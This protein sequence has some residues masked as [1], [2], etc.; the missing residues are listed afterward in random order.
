MKDP[1]EDAERDHGDPADPLHDLPPDW[2]EPKPKARRMNSE[3]EEE[4]DDEC[5]DGGDFDPPAVDDPGAFN[6]D[7]GAGTQG[8]ERADPPRKDRFALHALDDIVIGDDPIEL[9]RGILPMGPALGVVYGPPKSLK[10]FFVTHAGLHIAGNL[11]YCGREVQSGAVVYVTS[12]GVKG[13]RRRLVT[14]RR[15][16]GLEGKGVPFFLVPAMPNLG[17]GPR[18]REAL[19][20]AIEA[21]MRDL[22][23]PLR[24]IVID[25]MRRAMPGKSENKPEDISV[26]VDN[27]EALSRAFDCLVVLVHHSPRSDDDRGSGSNATDAAADVMIGC[28]RDEATKIATVTVHRLKDGEEGDAWSFELRPMEIGADRSGRPIVSRYVQITEEPERNL[29]TTKTGRAKLSAEQQRIYDIL[30]EAVA[31]EGV[32]GLAGS[33]APANTRAIT[34]TTLV[35]YLKRGGWWDK[36]KDHSSRS[37]MSARL[38][39]LAGKHAIG[40]TE[41]HVWPAL[42]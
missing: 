29:T 10:S 17:A 41:Q 12:E 14:A 5:F 19:Q 9:V 8:S 20:K 15:A 31:A 7:A 37:K 18:D 39:E 35:E 4:F 3:H 33:A 38:N 22:S 42:R 25:T 36:E 32:A 11:L 1:F 27:A 23:I 6:G 40:L 34:R 13:A 21:R 16:L 26:V 28:K 30:I 24:M 2:G